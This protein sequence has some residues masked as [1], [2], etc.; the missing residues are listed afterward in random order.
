M[1]TPQYLRLSL[2]RT[3]RGCNIV[4]WQ[5]GRM[6]FVHHPDPEFIHTL[7]T[8]E[9][10]A[11]MQEYAAAQT[12]NSPPPYDKRRHLLNYHAWYTKY[13]PLPDDWAQFEANLDALGVWEWQSLK[14]PAPTLEN[15]TWEIDI[16]WA[17][18]DIHI[19]GEWAFPRLFLPFCRAVSDLC[20]ERFN[21]LD[22]TEILAHTHA[23]LL[24][25]HIEREMEILPQALHYLQVDPH[26]WQGMVVEWLD[27][28]L[29]MFE[30]YLPQGEIF[31]EH[32][33]P[34][35][36]L[37]FYQARDARIVTPHADAWRQF[38]S[39]LIALGVW[40]WGWSYHADQAS[41]AQQWVLDVKHDDSRRTSGGDLNVK[42]PLFTP[43]QR[44]LTQLLNETPAQDRE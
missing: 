6:I 19:S 41:R 40:E 22:D 33:R 39:S 9:P 31:L 29:Y 42:P 4:E 32:W 20:G 10:A 7:E 16:V 43:F 38:W 13:E 17:D 5:D 28:T 37:R 24:H 14:H 3:E 1:M 34:A 30:G 2:A 35:D 44:V 8:L 26:S 15:L 36:R 18:R 11:R 12:L 21:L 23:P 27:D 25:L